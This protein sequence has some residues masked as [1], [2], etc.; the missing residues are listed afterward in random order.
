MQFYLGQMFMSCKKSSSKVDRG[1]ITY[2]IDLLIKQEKKNG[3][4]T[5]WW[6]KFYEQVDELHLNRIVAYLPYNSRRKNNM[7][8]LFHLCSH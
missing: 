7:L 3:L 2:H 4:E 5:E 8:F 1:T 6:W